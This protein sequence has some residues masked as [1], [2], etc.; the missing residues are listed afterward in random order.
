VAAGRRV[1]VLVSLVG[2]RRPIR[3]R[4]ETSV[5]VRSFETVNDHDGDDQRNYHVQRN[6]AGALP[7]EL[8]VGSN[9]SLRVT[10]ARSL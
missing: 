8:D 9:I 3:P 2:D 1:D 7:C 4:A 5:I 6:D 10:V